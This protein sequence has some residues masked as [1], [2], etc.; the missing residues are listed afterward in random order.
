MRQVAFGLLPARI[1]ECQACDALDVC[2]NSIRGAHWSQLRLLRIMQAE[3][4]TL[5]IWSL[6]VLQYQLSS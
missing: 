2:R 6:L 5:T 3:G 1:S 4:F